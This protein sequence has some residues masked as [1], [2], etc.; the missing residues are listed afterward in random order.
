MST[1][2]L[3]FMLLSWAF[4]LGLTLWAFG[5]IVGTRRRE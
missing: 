4:V 5:R 1:G 2:A 3:V